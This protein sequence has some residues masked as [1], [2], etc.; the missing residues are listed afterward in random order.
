[1]RSLHSKKVW[2]ATL[3]M[4]VNV[5][6][7]LFPAAIA[8]ADSV[9][10]YT[11]TDGTYSAIN[12]YDVHGAT[13]SFKESGNGQF[14]GGG[15]LDVGSCTAKIQLLNPDNSNHTQY[16]GDTSAKY[17]DVCSDGNDSTKTIQITSVQPQ[18]GT[19]IDHSH[20]QVGND[21][22]A[23]GKIDDNLNFQLQGGDTCTSQSNI[24]GFHHGGDSTSNASS[25]VTI[26]LFSVP[27]GGNNNCVQ[28]TVP[29]K[30]SD[31]NKVYGDYF[32]WQDAGTIST[33]DT[34]GIIFVQQNGSGPFK[35]DGSG[36]SADTTCVSEID[37]N[38]SSPSTGTL[39]IRQK[40]GDNP[41]LNT[42]WPHSIADSPL[43]SD[44][45]GCEVSRSI[46]ITIADPVTN[47]Q[48]AS[49]QAAG[50]SGI[51]GAGGG[52]NSAPALSCNAG[53]NPLN[54]LV[55]A[56]IKGLVSALNGVDDVIN[57]LL[58]VGTPSGSSSGDPTNIFDT[59][60]GTTGA[61]YYQAWSSF[62]DIALGLLVIVGLILVIAQAL[63]M[64]ILDAYTIRKV[65]PRLIMVSIGITLSWAILHFVIQLFNDLGYG[66]R[67]LIE[68]PFHGLANTS[69]LGGGGAAAVSL[70]TA[71]YAVALGIFGLFTF[72][73]AAMLAA[74]VAFIVLVARQIVVV[75]LLIV[76]PI[77][78]VCYILP[79]TQRIYKMWFDSFRGALVMFPL[80]VALIA[81][82][83]VFSAVA[84]N[85]A[86][87][88]GAASLNG[89]IA[90]AAYFAPYFMLP[91][92]FRMAGGLMSSI[93][94]FVNS[95]AQPGFG[96]L[97][98]KRNET[99]AKNWKKARSGQRWD[100]NYGRFTNP[101]TGKKTAIGHIGNRLAVNLLDQDE[102]IPARLGMQRGS[103]R[104]VP[105]FRKGAAAVIDAQDNRA[106]NES[107]KGVQEIDQAGGMH[108]EAWRALSGQFTDFKGKDKNG[109]LISQ[110][111]AAAGFVDEQ[112]N[113]K[114]PV[115]LSDFQKLSHIMME[116]D[117]D[118]EAQGGE[119]LEA[120]AGSLA[121]MKSHPDMEYADLQVM[122]AIGLAAQGRAEPEALAN[123][124]NS[125]GR[126]LNKGV[127]QRTL[128]TAM[129]VGV[130][131][132]P[133]LRD[134][135]GLILNRDTG[136]Y[137]SAYSAK[138]YTSATAIGSVTSVKGSDWSGAKAEAVQAAG[139]TLAHVA[140]GL[141]G[142]NDTRSAQ[143]RDDDKKT[144]EDSIVQ[145][146]ISPYNDAGQKKAWLNVARDA[147]WTEDRIKQLQAQSLRNQ[148]DQGS[149][150][151]EPPA[152]DGPAPDA[153]A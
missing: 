94:G 43:K 44:G 20:I 87:N 68:S 95:R 151:L 88:G 99:A 42:G 70:A 21:I 69:D 134:G 109:V 10:G 103:F 145:G 5:L 129:R 135:H 132:R 81:S 97:S 13:M 32:T 33:A 152:D 93:G 116:S 71:G 67:Y 40:A 48:K 100:K 56:V 79:N 7:P 98:K 51:G 73:A 15:V 18:S 66:V 34:T 52:D 58:A 106:I 17:F 83:R 57:S 9:N 25:T 19:W 24:D 53:F 50:S 104:G 111:I 96:A 16:D 126:R 39:I 27:G 65:L 108:Y 1:M 121:T 133:D 115:A 125:I 90:F 72:V 4:L 142:A 146:I 62:R 61:A 118:K 55:C 30:L 117:N 76:A 148:P 130:R 54:W 45:K 128:K 2:W 78:L 8:A 110:R 150:L 149:G 28:N 59:T 113:F 141:Q 136:E 124:G 23:D 75:A 112:G 12:G 105:G 140:M 63:G 114:Q 6:I 127:A 47:G 36:R 60:P 11:Y 92:T 89:Y 29:I 46:P 41:P 139:A 131:N 84:N 85:N 137:E 22:Y 80:I 147:G 14:T 101:F 91:A 74:L 102:L 82:G 107:V 153:P 3:L 37:A 122:G 31:P 119:D 144:I 38:V 123:I 77:A 64:E 35:D 120:H 49:D 138:N 143:E 86:N 26:H